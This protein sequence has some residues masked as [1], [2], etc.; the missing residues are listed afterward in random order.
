MATILLIVIFIGFIGLG[1]P[2]SLHGATW[3]SIYAQLNLPI[4]FGSFIITVNTFGTFVSSLFSARIINKF[5][6]GVVA[7]VSTLLTALSLLLYSYSDNM[8]FLC[9]ASFPLG[10]GGGAIDSGLNNYVALHYKAHHMNFLHCFYG[11]GVTLSPFVVSLA[12]SSGLSWRGGYRII[13]IAQVVIAAILFLSL[14]LW[15]KEQTEAR[16]AKTLS[17]RECAKTPVVPI[18]WAMFFAACS[19]EVTCGTWGSTYLVEAEGMSEASAAYLITFYYLGI[20]LGR[21]LSGVF[22][23][24]FSSIK[25]IIA[26]LVVLFFAM[27]MLILSQSYILSS[28][29]MF[30]IGLGIAPV[31]PGLMHLTP[32]IFGERVSQSIMGTNLAAATVGVMLMPFL[33]GIIAE[34]VSLEIYPF[35]VAVS[36]LILAVSFVFMVVNLKK[37]NKFDINIGR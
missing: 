31:Y 14:P 17:L 11:V 9:L 4:S 2:D 10:L 35:Y 24:R 36:F 32:H 12:L 29:A 28:V 33:F 21:F 19:V 23:F 37:Q 25:I 8:L 13:V 20:A 3:P 22:A 5:G 34:K 6:T 7:A 1:T 26:S 15:K 30:L 18:F 27:G 16:R